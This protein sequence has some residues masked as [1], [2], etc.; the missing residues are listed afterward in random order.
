M[1]EQDIASE[2][3]DIRLQLG[4]DFVGIATA[5]AGEAQKEIRWK[6]VA[7]NRNN[8]YQ[9]IVLQ[10]G[11]GIAGIVW[12]TARPIIAEDLKNDRLAPLQEYPI[13]LT[14]NLA[15][16]IAVPIMSDGSVIGVMLGG[17]RKVTQIKETTIDAFRI[18]ADKMQQS[19]QN[20]K[21]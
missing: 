18:T 8:R 19:L 1:K 14:E 12:R 3:I 17:Y 6:Y 20:I 4:L 9:K 5:V 7:G 10:V 21:E 2:L 16:I 13:A 11:K 15:S